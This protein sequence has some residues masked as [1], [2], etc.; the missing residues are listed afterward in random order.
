[1]MG[2][3]TLEWLRATARELH[4]DRRKLIP[5]DEV[6]GRNRVDSPLLVGVEAPSGAD[7]LAQVAEILDQC[8]AV[9]GIDAT[10][11]DCVFYAWRSAVGLTKYLEDGERLAERWTRNRIATGHSKDDWEHERDT[12]NTPPP[13][14]SEF[15]KHCGECAGCSHFGKGGSPIRF[16]YR[17]H[18]EGAQPLASAT[19]AVPFKLRPAVVDFSRVRVPDWVIPGFSAAGECCVW[20]G[21]PAVGKSTSIVGLALVVAG[22][23]S[24]IGSD[25]S[26][27]RPRRV[28]V[29]AEDTAQY[30]RIVHASCDLWGLDTT[31]VQERLTLYPAPRL[32]GAEIGRELAEVARVH[33]GSEPP[34][35][36][37]DTASAVF[38]MTDENSN[39][40][41]AKFIA[42][43]L[44]T[45]LPT[46]AAVWVIAHAAK[47][48]SKTDEEALPR[49]AS[50]FIG[51]ASAT[52]MVFRSE[53]SPGVT[54]WKV[55][56]FRHE[57]TITEIAVETR[58]HAVQ[59]KDS[60]GAPSSVVVRVGVPVVSSA[61]VRKE[62]A[63]AA[64]AV[65]LQ[66][67]ADLDALQ[68]QS[69]LRSLLAH[70]PV[71]VSK[72]ARHGS[73]P[74]KEFGTVEALS[75]DRLRGHLK[76]NHKRAGAALAALREAGTHTQ[77]LRG[78][79]LWTETGAADV[80]PA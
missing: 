48:T 78:W 33:T 2:N 66:T 69:F 51:N 40:E 67:V 4:P 1:M 71:A 53:A 27:P 41:A 28:A 70:K 26:N 38:D 35:I 31:Q 49:G 59:G 63:K 13:T 21:Q 34:L 20:A 39:A 47:P 10:G 15:A 52:G 16:G 32:S 74:P 44:E 62:K 29:V 65:E 22:F 24:A 8:G 79:L 3:L 14:C 30:E 54:F 45:V 76:C 72:G 58:T 23:G 73:K 56:K 46:G 7:Q 60:R 36:A 18:A 25:V 6:T 64:Q 80:K 55:A 61:E 5:W 17:A 57:A 9:A 12:W 43:I 11:G 68:A 42:A 75:R 77:E 19:G 37:I 50:A